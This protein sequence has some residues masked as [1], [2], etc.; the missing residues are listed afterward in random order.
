MFPLLAKFLLPKLASKV[1]GKAAA[2]AGVK[3]APKKPSRPLYITIPMV[4]SAL[5]FIPAVVLVVLCF[6]AGHK[7]G[8]M[9]EYA[10]YTANVSRIGENL[11]TGMNQQIRGVNITMVTKRSEIDLPAVIAV[12]PRADDDEE[13]KTSSTVKPS[14]ISTRPTSTAKPTTTN[15]PATT[16]APSEPAAAAGPVP[17]AVIASV[18][19]A[20]GAVIDK[21]ELHD[22]YDFHVLGRCYGSYVAKNGSQA[23]NATTGAGPT[24]AQDKLEKKVI[25]CETKSSALTLAAI[26]YGFAMICTA[27]A[28]IASIVSSI[29]YRKKFVLITLAITVLALLGQLVSSAAAHAIAKSATGLVDF[30]GHP[31]GIDGSA[32]TKFITLTGAATVILGCI[33]GIWGMLLFF[34]RNDPGFNGQKAERLESIQHEQYEISDWPQNPHVSHAPSASVY[35]RRTDGFVVQPTFPQGTYH[36]GRAPVGFI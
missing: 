25:A 10:V 27:T 15:K 3:V 21:L 26:A 28:F 1:V 4:L 12:A 20:F 17:S 22:F 9:D 8:M 5:L 14:T 31:V 35:S 18:N 7:P 2:A 16:P 23:A 24:A 32:G 36:Q 13:E 29:F 33:A 34:G 19:K 6:F 11:L 30:V